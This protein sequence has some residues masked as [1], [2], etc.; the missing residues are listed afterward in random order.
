MSV[1]CLRFHGGWTHRGET[2]NQREGER[3][4][5]FNLS[6]CGVLLSRSRSVNRFMRLRVRLA[7][8]AHRTGRCV[9]HP[10]PVVFFFLSLFAV[11]NS[12]GWV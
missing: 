5:V 9:W 8:K 7:A 2:A 11:I 3:K 1:V 12:D 10:D 4:D 6:A